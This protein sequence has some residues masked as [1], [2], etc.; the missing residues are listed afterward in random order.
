M[1][2]QKLNLQ[3]KAQHDKFLS[4]LNKS[5]ISDSTIYQMAQMNKNSYGYHLLLSVG[6]LS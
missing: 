3:F 6:L 2:L 5:S 1:L 4:P